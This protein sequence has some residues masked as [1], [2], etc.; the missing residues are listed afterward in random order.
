MS[1]FKESF[2]KYIQQQLKLRE[3]I[4][5]LGN[6]GKGRIN[7]TKTIKLPKGGEVT[8]PPGAFYTNTI[9]RACVVRLS[10]GVDLKSDAILEGGRYENK[11]DLVGSG[12][13]QRYVLEGGTLIN[14]KNNDGKKVSALRRGFPGAGKRGFGFT[15]GDPT[16]RANAGTGDDN[17]G[18]VPMPGITDANIRTKSAYGS[19]REAKVNF[20]CHNQ[21]QL[22][23][24]ELLYMRP[25]YCLLLEWGW[26]T[27]IDND[28]KNTSKFPTIGEFFDPN[29]SQ[30]IINKQI[31]QNKIDTGGNYDGM[32]GICKN[33]NYTSRTDGGYDC[34]TEIT[35]TGEIIESLKATKQ[36]FYDEDGNLKIGDEVENI[37]KELV[38]VINSISESS[39]SSTT[40]E[41]GSGNSSCFTEGTKITMADKTYKNI[42]DIK[43][44]DEVLSYNINTKE[45]ESAKVNKLFIH[46]DCN[47]GLILNNIIKTTTNHPFY[48][49]N[50]WI[51]AGNLKI[52][53]EILYV[54][55]IKHKITNIEPNTNKQT[56]YNFK[57]PGNH[58]Y[59][60]EGY[61]V[62]NK[63]A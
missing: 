11:G 4:V 10:S 54:S 12:L 49:N 27:Y 17:Y 55:G 24:L 52:G 6:D 42:E 23:I 35:S 58:N 5:S 28:G 16:I 25:G 46:E 51:E 30:E 14:I 20:V 33:F 50:D 53:D 34:T 44:G 2:R 13:A 43:E 26:T 31:I 22:E 8:L 19:L 40:N 59:F 18:I 48:V 57:V 41:A 3:A 32:L 61:L 39:T 60:A 47:N 29:V 37:L 45:I 1:I 7:H 38:S 15:Y 21:R 56:V 62:H 9:N 36:A 63:N